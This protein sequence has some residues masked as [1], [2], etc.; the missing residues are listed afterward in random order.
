[1]SLIALLTYNTEDLPVCPAHDDSSVSEGKIGGDALSQVQTPEF[2]AVFRG[3]SIQPSVPGA[4]D[5]R[6]IEDNGRPINA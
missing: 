2:A 1:V 6:I 4:K 5:N 3:Q